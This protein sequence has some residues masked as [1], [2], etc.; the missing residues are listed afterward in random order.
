MYGYSGFVKSLEIQVFKFAF[1]CSPIIQVSHMKHRLTQIFDR[2]YNLY[3]GTLCLGNVVEYINFSRSLSLN[4]SNSKGSRNAYAVR[5]VTRCST[6]LSC[7][8]EDCVSFQFL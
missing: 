3:L 5:C 1:I 7:E 4:I 8:P 2:H 6:Q